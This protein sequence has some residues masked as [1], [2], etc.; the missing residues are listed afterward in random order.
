MTVLVATMTVI[1]FVTEVK[2]ACEAEISALLASNR[3]LSE[4]GTI[5]GGTQHLSAQQTAA[6]SQYNKS[7]EESRKCTER[8]IPKEEEAKRAAKA[9]A[10][11]A[12]AKQYEALQ[13]QQSQSIQSSHDFTDAVKIGMTAAQVDASEKEAFHNPAGWGRTVNTTVTANGTTEQW[14]YRFSQL[15]G[16]HDVYLYFQNGVLTAIQK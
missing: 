13:N 8:E 12:H 7:M 2:A 16:A 9:A 3:Y 6:C 11:R 15:S 14:V 10:N 1:C 5:C 4:T